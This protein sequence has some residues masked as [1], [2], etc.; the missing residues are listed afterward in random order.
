MI[1]RPERIGRGR[2]QILY[3]FRPQQTY[4]HVKGSFIARVSGYARDDTYG[5]PNIDHGYL[6]D[7]AM[8]FVERWRTEGRHRAQGVNDVER[9][10]SFPQALPLAA[11]HYDVV[12]PGRVYSRAW[13][14]IV[15]CDSPTCGCVW[16]APDPV[17]DAEW[18]GHCPRDRSHHGAR[19]LQFVF[20]HQCGELRHMAP[21][22]RCSRCAGRYFRLD[23]R[24]SRFMDF[25]WECLGCR[26]A[27]TVATSCTNPQCTWTNKLMSPQVHTASAAYVGQGLTLVNV[28]DEAQ[29]RRRTNDDYVVAV[30][31]RWLDLCTQG[32]LERILSSEG[33]TAPTGMLEAIAQL[34]AAG[35]Q[36]QADDLRRRFLPADVGLRR[37]VAD[38]L[39]FIPEGDDP[40]TRRL[41]DNLEVYQRVLRRPRLSIADI[42]ATA[43][44]ER[45]R[46]YAE[47]PDVLSRAGFDPNAVFL[48]TSFP[49]TRLAVGY[50]RNGFAPSEADLVPYRGRAARGNA[51]R[52]Q[53]YV[54]PTETEALLFTLNQN[55]VARW[56]TEAALVGEQELAD[57]GGARQWFARNAEEL[58]GQIPTWDPNM[59]PEVGSTRA[60]IVAVF[61]LIHSLAH[62]MLRAL[63]VEAG[64]GEAGLSEYLFP[65]D[66]AFAVYPNASTEFT[67]GG[68]RTVVEQVLADVVMRAMESG[69]CLYDPNCFI[70]QPGADLGCLFLPE[71]ACSVWNRFLTRWALFGR[72]DGGV[73][74][75]QLA[76]V[77][78][79]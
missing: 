44:A 4:D 36:E 63:A 13:P 73:G 48:I 40:R 62:Q 42:A 64:F 22:V 34:E 43:T 7:K 65:F 3:R 19:Q 26:Q 69:T 37:R 16:H 23:D 72:P 49:I 51:E 5:G 57:A 35:L 29:A 17:P 77:L 66:L 30:L 54:H 14:H 39:G 20:V 2:G 18:P 25:R 41:A 55:R 79:A 31:A 21:P 27:I 60:A 59:R 58:E 10:P 12:V 9:A 52:T 32:E 75:W 33:A 53:L 38:R 76:D 15:R 46:L 50:S 6:I 78:A 70:S 56:L 67:I 61:E 71:T 28:P 11:Q 45:A 47:Y 68:L 8:R 1:F 24:L 74:Y